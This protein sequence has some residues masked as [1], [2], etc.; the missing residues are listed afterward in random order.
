M[1][2]DHDNAH[3]S[4]LAAMKVSRADRVGLC[5]RKMN[6]SATTEVML[7]IISR[8]PKRIEHSYPGATETQNEK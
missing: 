8:S 3:I 5:R 2:S 4:E 7:Y 6:G 1:Y